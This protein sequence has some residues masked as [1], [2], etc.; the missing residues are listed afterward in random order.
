[1][2]LLKAI[3]DYDPINDKDNSKSG[4]SFKKGDF[5]LLKDTVGKSENWGEGFNVTGDGKIFPMN[6]V[7]DYDRGGINKT[8]KNHKKRRTKRTKRT[9]RKKK[10]SKKKK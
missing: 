5:I 2:K 6:F 7:E 1:M 8:K 9:K 3:H 4:L 10:K